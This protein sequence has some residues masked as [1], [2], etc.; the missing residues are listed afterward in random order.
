MILPKGKYYV[1]D[2]CY[3]FNKSW[4]EICT[5]L[6]DEGSNLLTELY[7]KPVFIDSTAY[8]DG[9][10]YD[11][12]SRKYYVDAGLI[13]C[14]PISLLRKDSKQTISSV[15]KHE[16]MHIIDFKEDF[17]VSCYNGVFQFGEIIIDTSYDDE[18]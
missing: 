7:K 10:Y 12:F 16:G 1:G 6:F 11:Q 3:I 2:P 8:G 15:Q 13:G 9:I 17:E 5:M 18:D 14:L 4:D